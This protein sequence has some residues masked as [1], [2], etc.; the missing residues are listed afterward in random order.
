MRKRNGNVLSWVSVIAGF[1]ICTGAL[2]CSVRYVSEMRKSDEA[3]RLASE[4]VIPKT[5]FLEQTVKE[6]D[7]DINDLKD[8]EALK[9]INPDTVGFLN[10]QERE[11]PVVGNEDP[12][13]YLKTGWDGTRT[14]CGTIFTDPATNESSKNMILYGHNMKSGKMFGMLDSYLDKEYTAAHKTFRYINENYIDTYKVA[15]VIRMNAEDADSLIDMDLKSDFEK[16]EESAD[17]TGAL[18]QKL[19]TGCTYMTL[20]TCEYSKRNGRLLVIGERISHIRRPDA[21]EV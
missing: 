14:S 17:E 19:H 11:L 8:F 4:Y 6:A 21:K 1:V 16:L 20:A 5:I 12:K 2:F 18:Y 7:I 15:A 10:F 9:N 13:K 3:N